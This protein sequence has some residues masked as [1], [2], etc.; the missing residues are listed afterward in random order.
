M[1]WLERQETITRDSV[2]VKIDAV[3]RYRIAGPARAILPVAAYRNVVHQ[4][5]LTA[6]RNIVGQHMLD[7][8]LKDRDNINHI[9]QK[10][11][12]DSTKPWVSR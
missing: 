6:L 3:L 2:T 8:V 12:G 10:I 11:V 7:D 5:A 1:Q 4:V 9:L